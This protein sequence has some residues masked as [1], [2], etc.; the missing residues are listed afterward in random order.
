MPPICAGICCPVAAT[1]NN[2]TTGR[3]GRLAGKSGS[4]ADRSSSS[5]PD[6]CSDGP[7]MDFQ[8]SLLETTTPPASRRRFLVLFLPT[9]PTDYLKRVDPRL[10]SPL[11]LYER[12][13]GGLR[14]SALD[15]EAGQAGIRLG[16]S[17]A[18]A[19][20]LVPNLV[21]QEMN[22]PQL[23]AG[24]ADFAD[25]HSYASPMVAVMEDIS[26]FGDLVL[27]ITGV[28][29]L[30]G[31]ERAMLRILL[32]RLR[33]LGYTVA[34]AIAPTIGAAW[35]VSHFARG[36]V[37]DDA[38][39][40]ATIDALPVAAL[41]LNEQQIAVLTQMGLKTIGQ[42]RERSRKP[43]QARFG[44]SLLVRLDQAYG[45]IEERMTPRLPL[46][47]QHVERRF[48]EPIGLMD[49]VLACMQDLAIQLAYRLEAEGKG[50]QSFHL[51]LYRIDHKVMTLSVN[52]A[53]VTRDPQHI[54]RL[55]THR[56]ERLAGE[57][58]AGFGIDM[59]RLAASSLD[60]LEA[61]QLGA[62]SGED[63]TEDLDQLND[64]IASRLGATAVLRTQLVASHLP[65]RAAR[66]VPSQAMPNI[67]VPPQPRLSRP[68]RLLPS[69]ELVL[70]N[71]E[72]P[73]GLP[74]SM[75]WRRQP[76]RLVKGAGP[77]RLGAEWWRKQER[78]LLAPPPEP[79]E[80][81]P[82]EKPEPPPYIPDLPVHEPE[83]QTRDYYRV[84]DEDGRRFWVFRLGFYSGGLNP[85]WYLQG[86]FA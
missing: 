82:G 83:Q 23:E 21:I 85:S 58:D 56:A 57:Y 84:E 62:F 15:S 75:I 6:G 59:I 18:D 4:N 53:R 17:V 11:A 9:W 16:Q 24:F 14:I 13:K 68:L 55:F 41:R 5:M 71:A 45:A 38:A 65:E 31:G 22:R 54:T 66:L 50:A 2:M 51:Q 73:D 61:S 39:L 42:L 29:H 28:D 1:E 26:R 34:G 76:Y 43:M 7:K 12:V 33:M 48:A 79:E 25:W 36:Q 35:A 19:R 77:E 63:G 8:A 74:A 49:D 69:P 27:D 30:F 37:V 3:Q 40:V 70:I 81:K 60:R 44:Q 80:P 67:A 86:F 64:R 10:A 72:V 47:E 46:V 20:A 78:L 52:S 32:T